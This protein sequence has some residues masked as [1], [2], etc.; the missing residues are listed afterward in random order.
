MKS[1]LLKV[2]DL[3]LEETENLL[4]KV[5]KTKN[6]YINEAIQHYNNFQSRK[7]LEKA[8]AKESKLVTASSMEVLK[9]FERIEYVDKAI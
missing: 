7:L 9:E 1:V 8:L 4:R 5:K 6:T 3:I 2:D